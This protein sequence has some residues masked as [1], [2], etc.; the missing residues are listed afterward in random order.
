MI[1]DVIAV[2]VILLA[3]I[4]N[5]KKGLVKSV[6]K[7]AALVLTIVLVIALKTPTVNYLAGTDFANRI[8]ASVSENLSVQIENPISE[9]NFESS[10]MPQFLISEMMK[11]V[12][13]DSIYENVNNNLEKGTNEIA[14]QLTMLMLKIIAVVG[15]FILIRILL[16]VLFNLLN[17]VSKLPVI[18]QANAL[19][20]GILGVINALAAIYIVCAL[21]SL[22]HMNNEMADL[23]N[24]SHLVKYFYNYNILL[25]LIMKI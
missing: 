4:I 21:M 18:G 17:G 2:A 11:T 25:Q 23:I 19:L 15:L 6:W 14:R 24:Q 1:L 9:E 20:G 8:Y 16:A 7:I 5:L 12:D 10:A 3:F 22:F 13:T